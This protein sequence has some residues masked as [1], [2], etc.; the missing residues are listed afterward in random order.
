MR[1]VIEI[2]PHLGLAVIRQLGA[3]LRSATAYYATRT[4]AVGGIDVTEFEPYP[5]DAQW[6]LELARE[7][8]GS[9]YARTVTVFA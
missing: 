3:P 7:M 5:G 8:L 4:H 6:A 9:R 2:S 1:T